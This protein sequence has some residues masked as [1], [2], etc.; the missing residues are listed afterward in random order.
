[1]NWNVYRVRAGNKSSISVQG[2]KKNWI[3]KWNR[4]NGDNYSF[5]CIWKYNKNKR[6]VVSSLRRIHNQFLLLLSLFRPNREKNTQ[7][8]WN[9]I[10]R[11]KHVYVSKV[12]HE[13]IWPNW[14]V[15]MNRIPFLGN[16]LVS[17]WILIYFDSFWSDNV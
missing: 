1:M 13:V 8:V 7:F 15:Y 2:N 12:C 5:D 10:C 9:R 11:G 4:C 3:M 14:P 6:N 16:F 17:F